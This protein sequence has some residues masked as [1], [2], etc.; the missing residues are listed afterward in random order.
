M[1]LDQLVIST[2]IDIILSA[3]FKD[4]TPQEFLFR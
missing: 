3:G 2:E 1:N 4:P